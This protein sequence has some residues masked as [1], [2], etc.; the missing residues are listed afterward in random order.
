MDLNEKYEQIDKWL[1]FQETPWG[2]LRYELSEYVLKK[3]T[4][5]KQLKILDIGGGNGK[6][7]MWLAK[8][9]CNITL[10]DISKN[11][12]NN[13]KLEYEK[14]GILDKLLPIRTDLAKGLNIS[15]N[16]EFDLILIHN[17]FSYINNVDQ[18]LCEAYSCLTSNGHLSIMQ[19]NKYSEIL[20]AII[21]ENDLDKA[22]DSIDS[23]KTKIELYDDTEVYRYSA[24]EL[25]DFLKIY[26]KLIAIRKK[27]K[28]AL[29][30]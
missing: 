19:V 18:I 6:E 29:F 28:K 22:Y 25:I 27:V 4:D 9:G 21:F 14:N 5:N 13:A 12:L 11:M 24:N 17:L 20:P 8:Q 26:S 2:K 15:F 16:H 10:I 3:Y 30:P 1:N 23:K 7:S